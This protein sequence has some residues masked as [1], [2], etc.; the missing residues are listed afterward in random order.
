MDIIFDNDKFRRECNDQ[1][2]LIRRH[3]KR[4]ADVIRRRLDDLAAAGVLEVMRTLPGR[5]HE[6][7]R[8][9]IGHLSIDLDGPYRLIF[10]PANSP[11]PVKDGGGLE[12]SQVTAITILGVENTHE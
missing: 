6:L 4:R 7:T 5:C 2:T 9:H 8:D 12:W 3:G 1:K 11:L 10:K